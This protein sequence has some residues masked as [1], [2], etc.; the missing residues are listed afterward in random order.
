MF[1]D[2]PFFYLNSRKNKWIYILSSSLF[3][4]VFLVLF[5]PYGIPEV[6]ANP[7]NSN[8]NIILFFF[9]VSGCVFLGISLS[10]F[11][12]RSL[13]NFNNVSNKKYMLWVLF[14]VLVMTLF[15]FGF[16]F[17][18]P[19]LGDNF[20]EELTV[21][22]QLKN[23]FRALIL[24]IFPFFGTIIYI[25][26]KG[27]NSE[28]EGLE[29]KLYKFQSNYKDSNVIKDRSLE[30]CDENNNLELVLNLSNFLFAES[31]NQYVLIHYLKDETHKKQIVRT[32]LKTIIETFKSLPIEQCHRSFV[33]NLINVKA[34]IK[35]E[36]KMVLAMDNLKEIS[37]PVSKSYLEAIKKRIEGT[38]IS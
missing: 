37:L 32:R 5:Q 33:V 4:L 30:I 11:F 21:L 29:S 9:T 36:G 1:L 6:V 26:I 38:G 34:L 19:D 18:I 10:Q 22:F 8:E 27:L 3:V 35:K 7:V 28:I 23:Y 31:C 20:E 24:M 2:Q 25:V 14:E 15:H 12:L 17:V 13:F 16:S